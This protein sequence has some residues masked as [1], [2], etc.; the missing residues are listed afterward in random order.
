MSHVSARQ[1]TSKENLGIRGLTGNGLQNGLGYDKTP[2][3]K[4]HRTKRNP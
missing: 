2:R 3:N 1:F 4:H